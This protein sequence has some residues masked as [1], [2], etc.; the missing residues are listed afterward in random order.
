MN[1]SVDYA[2]DDSFVGWLV[3]AISA[4]L[5]SQEF[6]VGVAVTV[7]IMGIFALLRDHRRGGEK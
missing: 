6:W 3:E 4:I 2:T 1:Y 7:V 5:S